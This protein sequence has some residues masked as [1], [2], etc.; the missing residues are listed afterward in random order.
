M[1]VQ[2]PP[3]IFCGVEIWRLVGPL[4]DLETLLKKPLLRCLGGVFGIKLL[5]DPDTFDLRP[6]LMEGGFHSK[7]HDTEF[8]PPFSQSSY[9]YSHHFPFKEN[10]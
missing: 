4:Q 10:V 3:K 7:S 6:L 5:K 9:Y 8:N 2:L 1:D